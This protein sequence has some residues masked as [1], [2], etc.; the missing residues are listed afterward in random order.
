[1]KEGGSTT[2]HDKVNKVEV[3]DTYLMYSNVVKKKSSEKQDGQH[4]VEGEENDGSGSKSLH[5]IRT[6]KEN[7]ATRLMKE[8]VAIETNVVNKSP[9]EDTRKDLDEKIDTLSKL[10]VSRGVKMQRKCKPQSPLSKGRNMSQGMLSSE[11][12]E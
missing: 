9:R 8:V 6:I 3:K 12:K 5:A 1:M 11:L 4:R 10:G 7:D 2:C